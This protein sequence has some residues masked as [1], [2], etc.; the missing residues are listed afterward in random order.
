LGISGD[1]AMALSLAKRMTRIVFGVPALLTWQWTE[2]RGRFE[3][4]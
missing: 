4:S 1:V 3:H 2:T